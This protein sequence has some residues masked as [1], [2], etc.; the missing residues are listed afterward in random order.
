[1]SI[2]DP[3]GEP[4]SRLDREEFLKILVRGGWSQEAAEDEWEIMPKGSDGKVDI[5]E[6]EW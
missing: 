1:M 6:L 2:N 3:D 4:F 5:R